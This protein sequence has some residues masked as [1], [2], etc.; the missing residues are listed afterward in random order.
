M[1][2][3]NNLQKAAHVELHLPHYLGG[4]VGHHACFQD[5]RE[6]LN[7]LGRRRDACY[8]TLKNVGNNVIYPHIIRIY[9]Y[10]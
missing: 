6:H 3:K 2:K 10:W 4:E 9:R 7:L 8:F 1:K 5:P